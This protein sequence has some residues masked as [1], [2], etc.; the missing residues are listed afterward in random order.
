MSSLKEVHPT[1]IHRRKT[2]GST[3]CIPG[4][5]DVA[6][7]MHMVSLESPSADYMIASYMLVHMHNA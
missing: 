3:I 2:Y 4:V 5:I 7:F 1:T 6:K